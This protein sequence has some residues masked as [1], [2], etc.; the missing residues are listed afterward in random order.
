[1]ATT[2]QIFYQVPEQVGSINKRDITNKT[3][4]VSKVKPNL[5]LATS[6]SSKRRLMS[7]RANTSN[8]P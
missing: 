7:A 1:M 4:I 3:Q 2:E 6:A 8:L 5:S